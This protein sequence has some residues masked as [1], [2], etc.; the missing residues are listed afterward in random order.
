M[1][2]CYS[3]RSGKYRKK[4]ISVIWAR[5]SQKTKNRTTIRP[6]NSTPEYIMGKNKNTNLKMFIEALFIIAK[7]GGNLCPSIDGMNG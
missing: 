3:V 4:E 1:T 2:L 5:I 7:Y 6:S